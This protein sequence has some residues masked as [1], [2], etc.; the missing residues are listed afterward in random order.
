MK[1]AGQR[2]GRVAG[3]GLFVF[4]GRIGAGRQRKKQDNRKEAN[5]PRGQSGERK[6][7]S[8]GFDNGEQDQ[9]VLRGV[10]AEEI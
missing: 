2:Q 9:H 8:I 6:Y 1:T 4:P 5:A 3:S 10:S 7:A